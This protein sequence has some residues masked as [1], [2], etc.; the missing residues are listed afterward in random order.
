[1]AMKSAKKQMRDFRKR[2][3]VKGFKQVSRWV[4]ETDSPFLLRL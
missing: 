4:C 3:K 2:V 1:M